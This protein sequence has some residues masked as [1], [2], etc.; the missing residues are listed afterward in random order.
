MRALLDVNVLIALLDLNH[1]D[2]R[3]ARGW[4]ERNIASGWASCPI[5]QNGFVRIVSQPAYPNAL[6]VAE[7][8]SRLERAVRTPHH[9]LWPNDLSILDSVWV[10]RT[11]LLGHRQVT[12]ASLLALAVARGGRFVTLDRN[13]PLAAVPAARSV[14]LEV[15]H[16]DT[17]A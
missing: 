17:R 11:R 3:L 6:T 7:G 1:V 15:L 8:I 5:T 14:H 12:D 4:I 9:E 10:D 16:A 2:H 13:I